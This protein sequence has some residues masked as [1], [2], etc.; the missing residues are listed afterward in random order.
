MSFVFS[1]TTMI[2]VE[3]MLKAATITMRTRMTNITTFSSFRA[4]KRFRL[5][6]IQSLPRTDTE[7][8]PDP[9]GDRGG[10]VD[11]PHLDLYPRGTPLHSEKASGLLEVDVGEGGVVL[12]HPRLGNADDAEPAVLGNAPRG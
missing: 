10:V 1:I 11:V 5:L 12:V 4:E 3:M 6:C 8:R 7:G 2:R 9:P